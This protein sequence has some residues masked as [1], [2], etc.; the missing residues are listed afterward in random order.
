MPTKFLFAPTP[1]PRIFRLSY[2]PGGD[3]LTLDY[4]YRSGQK[5]KMIMLQTKFF[6]QFTYKSVSQPICDRI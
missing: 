6:Q 4:D 3:E 2:G 5:S 1:L